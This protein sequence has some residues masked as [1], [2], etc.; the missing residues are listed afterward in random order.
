MS[1]EDYKELEWDED[2]NSQIMQS[3]GERYHN[4][5][6]EDRVLQ[7]GAFV[8]DLEFPEEIQNYTMLNLDFN[9]SANL[10][11]KHR[12]WDFERNLRQE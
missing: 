3:L 1:D 2:Q 12:Q 5:M 9:H 6:P 10:R 4:P 11:N 7:Y 8:D